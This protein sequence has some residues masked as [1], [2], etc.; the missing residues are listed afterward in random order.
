MLN[1]VNNRGQVSIE[2]VGYFLWVLVG[3]IDCSVVSIEI[4]STL[5]RQIIHKYQKH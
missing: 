5:I 3:I 4:D 1:P 2:C